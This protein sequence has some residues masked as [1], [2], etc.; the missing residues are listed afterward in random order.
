MPNWEKF[1]KEVSRKVEKKVSLSKR[2]VL[3][4]NKSAYEALGEPK[5]VDLLF[6]KEESLVGIQSSTPNAKTSFKVN[7]QQSKYKSYYVSA[8]SFCDYYQIDISKTISF[9]DVK[10]DNG[11][12]IL[13]LKKATKIKPK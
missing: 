12:L 3:S 1:T 7:E 9:S 8:K 13:D 2:G 11:I 10:I 4:L 5:A 6:D